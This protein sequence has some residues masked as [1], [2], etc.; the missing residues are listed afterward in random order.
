[1][2]IS[3]DKFEQK[4]PELLSLA[5]KAQFSLSKF[6]LE[7]IQAEVSFVLDASGS[8]TGQYQ[9]GQVQ[10]LVERV[11]P[12]AAH[13]DNNDSMETWAFADKQQQLSSIGFDNYKDFVNQDNGGWQRWMSNLNASYNNE[14]VVMRA[15]IKHFFG[16]DVPKLEKPSSGG[17]GFFGFGKKSSSGN[18]G[19]FAPKQSPRLPIWVMFISDGGVAHNEDIEFI[20]K[21]SSTLPIFWQFMGIGGSSYGSL[22]KFDDLT[23]RFIDNADFFAIDNLKSISEQQLYDKMVQEFP[24]WITLAKSHNMITA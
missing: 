16:L 20:L 8:M 6:N 3:L 2:A 18:E 1:M 23:G 19:T 21:W 22:E 11:F 10:S 14:P 5:K 4:A 24:Q 13:F 12:V 17:G 7:D 15:I 9:T